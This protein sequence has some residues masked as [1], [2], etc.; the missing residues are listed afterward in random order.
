LEGAEYQ[1]QNSSVFGSEIANPYQRSEALDQL[2][3][4]NP[5]YPLIPRSVAERDASRGIEATAG[6]SWFETARHGKYHVGM[7]RTRASSP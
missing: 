4:Q 6:P 5:F 7:V 3:R 1:E 2:L